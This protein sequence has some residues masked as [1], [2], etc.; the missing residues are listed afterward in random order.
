VEALENRLLPTAYVVTTTRDILNDTT[1]GQL[2]LRD[3]ITALDGIPS[4]NA[5]AIQG[6]RALWVTWGD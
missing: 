4:G 1:P 2:T 6:Q 5:T 3:A